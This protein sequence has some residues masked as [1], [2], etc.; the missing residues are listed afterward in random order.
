MHKHTSTGTETC[1]TR[2]CTHIHICSAHQTFSFKCSHPWYAISM[3]EV[4]VFVKNARCLSFRAADG[5]GVVLSLYPR[6]QAVI[7]VQIFSFCS[8]S[9]THLTLPTSSYV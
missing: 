6:K 1:Y 7:V 3:H 2:A 4:K 8:V 9:Y 5:V